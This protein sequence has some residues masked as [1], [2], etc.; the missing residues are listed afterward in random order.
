[1]P[2][3]LNEKDV[4]MLL[5][6]LRRLFWVILVL[7]VSSVITFLL[8]FAAPGDPA[9]RLAAIRPGDELLYPE[10]IEQTRVAYG[11]DKP[12]PVQYVRYVSKLVRGDFGDSF[13][14]K[15][16]VLEVLL[17]KLP[18]TALLAASI[19]LVAIVL[20]IPIGIVMAVRS[21]SVV[22]RGLLAFG[23]LVISLPGFLVGLL[24]LFV[25]A[26]NLKLLPSSGTGS[27]RHLILPT[28]SGALPTA[29]AYAFLLRTNL[30]T[31]FDQDYARTA[32]AKGLPTWRVITKHV[33][34]NAVLPVVTLASID[35]AT[36]LTGIVLIEQV[37]SWPGLGVLTLQAVRA[38]DIPVVM[39]S[40]LFAGALIGV[41]NLIADVIA[42]RLDPRIRLGS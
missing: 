12:I 10:V 34:P 5:F 9:S 37:F 2:S 26:F 28:L 7:V 22:D 20:G 13:Y 8:I 11:L 39:G 33:L 19:M 21:D 35:L 14:F 41:G 23:S 36:L 15:R 3:T 6:I 18:S 42:A 24:L 27:W 17:A 30:L 29:I 1:M 31:M 4:D 25:F 40:V 32:K 16:P 38:T